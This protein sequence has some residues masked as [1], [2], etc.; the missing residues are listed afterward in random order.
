VDAL[1]E[2]LNKTDS[3]IAELNTK[4]ST[5]AAQR[6]AAISYGNTVTA[7]YAKAY[8]AMHVHHS[9]FIKVITLGLVRDHHLDLPAPTT[10][11]R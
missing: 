9:K 4:L 6:D 10:L 8:D 3:V 5:V 11:A 2:R 7:L 1:N